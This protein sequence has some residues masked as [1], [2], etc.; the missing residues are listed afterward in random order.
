MRRKTLSKPRGLSRLL[1]RAPIWLYKI[2]LGALLGQRFLLLTHTGRITGQPRQTVIEVVNKDQE[3]GAYYVV[4]AWGE[5]ADWLLNVQRNPLCSVQVGRKR[6]SAQAQRLP[7]SQAERVLLDYAR[8]HPKALRSLAAFSGFEVDGS[9][10][11]YRR[12]ARQ[13]PTVVLHPET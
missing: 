1:L 13:L 6:F 9:E 7:D 12:M 10:E 11:G 8:R 5:R 3:E 2:R 4:S